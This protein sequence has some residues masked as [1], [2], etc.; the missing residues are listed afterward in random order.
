MTFGPDPEKFPPPQAPKVGLGT[1]ESLSLGP[2]FPHLQ[3]D[4]KSLLLRLMQNI[5]NT[6]HLFINCP[7]PITNSE[8]C[9]FSVLFSAK[10]KALL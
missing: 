4:C 6:L 9:L 3:K 1:W 2:Q 10:I 8:H 5:L 7:S